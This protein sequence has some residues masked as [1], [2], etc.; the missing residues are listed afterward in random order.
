MPKEP[1]VVFFTLID[2]GCITALR[3]I[4]NKKVILLYQKLSMKVIVVFLYRK[5]K[6]VQEIF[7]DISIHLIPCK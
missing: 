2:F 1:Y 6:D 4:K 5:R 7:S 3:W